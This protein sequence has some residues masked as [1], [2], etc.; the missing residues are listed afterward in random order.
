MSLLT[1]YS[2]LSYHGQQVAHRW[3][4]WIAIS[5]G[6][7]HSIVALSFG[8]PL[9]HKGV[10]VSGLV[11]SLAL[12]A[13]II[14]SPLRL[15]ARTYETTVN[16]HVALSISLLGSLWYHLYAL[17]SPSWLGLIY[18]NTAIGILVIGCL[19]SCVHVLYRSYRT[20]WHPGVLS[21]R[22]LT[23]AIQI[24]IEV[25]R[26]WTFRAGQHIY[27]RV[28]G[29]GIRALWQSHPFTVAW[30]DQNRVTLLIRPRGGFTRR[31]LLYSG[32][33]LHGLVEGPF[34][35]EHDLRP[36][37]AIIMFASGVGIAAQVPY[38]RRVL[39]GHDTSQACTQSIALYWQLDSEGAHQEWV[40]EWMDELLRRDM[41]YILSI[42]VFVS[43]NYNDPLACPRGAECFGEHHRVNRIFGDLDVTTTLCGELSNRR[44]KTA[45]VVC[46]GPAMADVVRH[47]V[48]N[49]LRRNVTLL[50]LGVWP[51]PSGGGPMIAVP[52]VS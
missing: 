39:E 35:T 34:G 6:A 17:P 22:Q 16:A 1:S 3:L 30:W 48:R 41:H 11:A 5:N 19:L 32:C 25:P 14:L 50:E 23:D 38:I 37:G 7:I 12:L 15:Y 46:A 51:G 36:Y 43:G 21:I 40:K 45:V 13:M 47:T 24:T 33:R 26:P 31:L 42:F 8:R 10:G 18:L 27:L 44:G 49:A 28:I 52:P 20:G 2:L 29:M 4:G 9:E